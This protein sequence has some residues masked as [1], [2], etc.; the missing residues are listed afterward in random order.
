MKNHFLLFLVIMSFGF[1]FISCH[2]NSGGGDS[3]PVVGA[4]PETPQVP[5][6]KPAFA[7][8][9]HFHRL[10]N[11]MGSPE[12]TFRYSVVRD[13]DYQNLRIWEIWKSNG[14]LDF[15]MID[16]VYAAHAAKGA[17]VIKVFSGVPHWA[18]RDPNDPDPDYNISGRRSGPI[19]L[20][21]YEKMV[22]NFVSHTQNSLWAV[23]GENETFG[24]STSDKRMFT[25]TSTLLADM[26]KRLYKATKRVNPKILVISPTTIP[27]GIYSTFSEAKTSEGEPITKYFD[28]LGFHL[29]NYTASKIGFGYSYE[30]QLDSI[31]NMTIQLGIP[32]VMLADT[33]HG[34]GTWNPSDPSGKTFANLT[35]GQKAVVLYETTSVAKSKGLI[36]IGWYSYETDFI[37]KP[38]GN[39]A[40][41]QGLDLIFSTFAGP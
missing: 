3:T 28:V 15:T 9:M 22:E 13:W 31:R 29:Y 26:Q 23:E 8:G 20:N 10:Y 33:E 41:S 34:W 4:A 14:S 21:A 6:E 35:S 19:D 37:G 12:P 17:K 27:C 38:M 7:V 18:A 40:L 24:C 39:S 1:L 11:G 30:N 2:G 16:Q 25:G 5:L 32:N 36:F